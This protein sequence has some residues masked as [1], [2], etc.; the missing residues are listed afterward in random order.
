MQLRLWDESKLNLVALS[1]YQTHAEKLPIGFINAEWEYKTSTEN[2]KHGYLSI[3]A[4]P[5]Q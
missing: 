2:N 4:I 1:M 3:Y 5:I